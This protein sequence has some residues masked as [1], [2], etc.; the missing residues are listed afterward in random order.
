MGGDTMAVIANQADSKMK[1]VFNAGV[2]DNNKTI[3]KSKTFPRVKPATENENLYNLG[4]AISELQSHELS[5]IVR[6]EE[7]ELISEV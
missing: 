5:N 1:I 2:D 7:Y 4:V 6:Y 3:L